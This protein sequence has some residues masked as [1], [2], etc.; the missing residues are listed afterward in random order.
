MIKTHGPHLSLSSP[1]GRHKF[2]SP[3]TVLLGIDYTFNY[4][5]E[6]QPAHQNGNYKLDEIDDFLS[7]CYRKFDS[8]HNCEITC[9]PELS[10][11]GRWH[12]HGI[13]RFTRVL[14]FYIHDIHKLMAGS[15]CEVDS[16]SDPEVWVTYIN[17][18]KFLMDPYLETHSKHHCYTFES[19]GSLSFSN[20]SI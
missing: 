12:F 7:D 15:A 11:T 19:H 6:M 20:E 3:E 4:N 9:V 8:C 16:I 2:P 13:L 14:L 17:K 18:Q 10:S 5:P 1:S